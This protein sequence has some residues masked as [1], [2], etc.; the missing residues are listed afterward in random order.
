MIKT[1]ILRYSQ[2]QFNELQKKK[3]SISGANWE[4]FVYDLVMESEKND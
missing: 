4:R 3:E 1:I 2:K